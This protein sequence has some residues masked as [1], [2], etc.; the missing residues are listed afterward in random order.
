MEYV[1]YGNKETVTSARI[2]LLPVTASR[3]PAQ[4]T[5]YSLA[6]VANPPQDW[7]TLAT[8]SV[9]RTYFSSFM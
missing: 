8:G 6:C 9:F 2:A 4:S 3:L 7:T 1:D 5:L